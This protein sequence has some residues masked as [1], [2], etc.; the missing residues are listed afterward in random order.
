MYYSTQNLYNLWASGCKNFTYTHLQQKIAC[1]NN[2]IASIWAQQ[3][4][5]SPYAHWHME[6]LHGKHFRH[7]IIRHNMEAIF[8]IL[9]FTILWPAYCVSDNIQ[10]CIRWYK[11][12]YHFSIY[13][14]M[15]KTRWARPGGGTCLHAQ[16]HGHRMGKQVWASR[17]IARI[18]NTGGNCRSAKRGAI[19]FHDWWCLPQQ[20]F[21]FHKNQTLWFCHCPVL[22]YSAKKTACIRY[23]LKNN[24]GLILWNPIYSGGR[25]TFR[26]STTANI[27]LHSALVQPEDRGSRHSDSWKTPALGEVLSSL[28][29][30]AFFV[31]RKRVWMTA[32]TA[33][34]R[35]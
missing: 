33:F 4:V 29:S 34:R 5:F 7:F 28:V 12:V 10:M 9:R 25:W 1:F 31:K 16:N 22:N 20:T 32:A 24:I 15:W 35:H 18:V 26:I 14:L 19:D 30:A 6:T 2:E 23:K 11:D 3:L 21:P 8:V 17:A 13:Y 27:Y